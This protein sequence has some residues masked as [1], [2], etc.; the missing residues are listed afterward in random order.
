MK[1]NNTAVCSSILSLGENDAEVTSMNPGEGRSISH[2]RMETGRDEMNF[3]EFPLAAL[4]SRPQ[5]K[6]GSLVFEDTVQDRG[7]GGPVERRLVVS[8]SVEYALHHAHEAGVIHRDLKPGNIIL[9]SQGEPHI[10]D[11]GLARREC[12]LGDTYG[13]GAPSKSC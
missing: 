11:F 1:Q 12:Y 8:P 5:T 6:Q 2:P 9:D 4:T 10:M 13:S 3:A 7:M